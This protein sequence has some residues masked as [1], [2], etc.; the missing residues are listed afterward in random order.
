VADIFTPKLLH[1]DDLPYSPLFWDHNI[2]LTLDGT[3]SD[4]ILCICPN[5]FRFYVEGD[6]ELYV[7]LDSTIKVKDDSA[8]WVK[9]AQ[10]G[11]TEPTSEKGKFFVMFKCKG[12]SAY[13]S[14]T[15][16]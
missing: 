7:T 6:Y 15:G 11:E 5:H 16:L 14:M 10:T 3:L 9:V 4:A 2:S 13:I 12:P 8:K 1:A